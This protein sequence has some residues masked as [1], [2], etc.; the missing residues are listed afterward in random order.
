MNYR[1]FYEPAT[2]IWPP[3]YSKRKSVTSSIIRALNLLPKKSTKNLK[4]DRID[5]TT[6]ALSK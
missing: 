3:I 2:F 5:Y 1:K 6:L 4:K